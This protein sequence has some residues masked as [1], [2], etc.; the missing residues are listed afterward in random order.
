MFKK[1]LVLLISIAVGSMVLAQT[2]TQTDWSGGSGVS[3]PVLNW[4]TTF[5]MENSV[6]WF[7]STGELILDYSSPM[8]HPVTG[9]YVNVNYIHPVDVDGDGDEDILS[10][11]G[12]Y[13]PPYFFS[14][15]IYWWENIDGNGT[16][17]EYNIVDNNFPSAPSICSADLDGDDDIDIIG[18]ARG[19]VNDLAWWENIDGSGINWTEH[20]I[21]SSIQQGGSVDTADV[22]NDG[23]VDILCADTGN[24]VVWLENVDGSGNN[25]IEHIIGY[26][27]VPYD[28]YGADVDGDEDIDVVVPSYNGDYIRW[29]ENVDGS[30]INWVDHNVTNNFNGARSVFASDVD[31]DGDID[32][33]GAA[34]LEWAI[35]WWENSD[36][37]GNSWIEHNI[38]S[39]FNWAFAV[40]AS[41]MD[42][43]GDADV[44]GAAYFGDDITWWENTDGSGLNWQEHLIDDNFD[45]AR[46]V[47][48]AD[49]D[50]DGDPD[51]IGVA[52]EDSDISWWD[53]TCCVELGEL[54]SS[55]LDI[56]AGA[57][58]DS[59]IWTSDEPTETS[60]YF[61]VRSS[62][63]PQYMGNWSIDITTPGSLENY[64]MDGDQYV[65]YKVFLETTNPG[66]SPVLEDVTISWSEITGIDDNIIP[67]I[68]KLNQNYPNPFNPETEIIYSLRENSKVSLNIYN[69][70]GQKVKQLISDQ[71]PEGQHSVVW[72][73]KDDNGKSVSSGIY[74]YKLK[75]EN[76][77]KTKRMVLLK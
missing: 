17:W 47:V 45:G 36:G 18:L 63:D 2:A 8:E 27:N 1:K 32:I 54:V 68:T 74:F 57:D 75:T 37:S 22:N 61:Q 25:W 20:I 5:D 21:P 48:T 14:G 55:I 43:D 13:G 64:L 30:G 38:S 69:I 29:W 6:N 26:N 56:E 49:M 65:Q 4:S 12:R 44:I 76:Y 11:A 33:L 10:A 60:L 72:N 7:S 53:V 73:G 16:N 62:M 40:C 52:Q 41:D 67:L 50:G 51:I 66:F 19:S 31:G 24:E 39:N 35:T 58:W 23:Y 42:E 9:G 71:L 3:G 59:L 15:S 77:E 34:S 28:V 46:D 70:K